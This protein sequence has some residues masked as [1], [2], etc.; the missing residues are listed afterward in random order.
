MSLSKQELDHV[1][2]LTQV[3]L[4]GNKRS[5]MP[6]VIQTLMYIVKSLDQVE[7][8]EPVTEAIQEWIKEIEHEL[9]HET[10]RLSEI[11]HN[12]SFNKPP[13]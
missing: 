11:K 10:R 13:R 9:I 7:L 2:F 1:L 12:L 4:E 8:S 5:L 3:V 6:G